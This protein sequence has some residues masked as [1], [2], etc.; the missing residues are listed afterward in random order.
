MANPFKEPRHGGDLRIV[1]VALP[2]KAAVHLRLNEKEP[3]IVA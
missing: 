1:A 2:I 3:T